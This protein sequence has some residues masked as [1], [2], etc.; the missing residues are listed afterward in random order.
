MKKRANST[1]ISNPYIDRKKP[2][3]ANDSLFIAAENVNMTSIKVSPHYTLT[4]WTKEFLS[5]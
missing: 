1:I 5:D 2:P 3:A 4:H